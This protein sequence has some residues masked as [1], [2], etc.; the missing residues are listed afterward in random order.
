[1]FCKR[2]RAR[3]QDRCKKNVQAKAIKRRRAERNGEM[4]RRRI[5]RRM[6]GEAP[7]GGSGRGDDGK[8]GR[9][10]WRG[11]GGKGSVM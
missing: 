2:A 7:E 1:M 4:R 5:K 9:V 8:R 10:M 6:G 11:L 3:A